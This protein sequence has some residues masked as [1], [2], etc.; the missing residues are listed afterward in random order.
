MLVFATIYIIPILYKYEPD[1]IYSNTISTPFGGM[2]SYILKVPNI[3]HVREF[4][5]EDHGYKFD[6]GIENTCRFIDE[7]SEKIIYNSSA[8]SNKYASLI[9]NTHE[10]TIHNGPIN[11]NK[12]NS[13][14]I[15]ENGIAEPIELVIVGRVSESK[16]QMEAIIALLLIRERVEASLRIVGDGD[17]DYISRCKDIAKNLGLENHIEWVGY[18]D[19]IDEEYRDADVTIVP[20]K[21]EAF[22]RVVI[23]S[24]ALG[25]PVVGR[26]S[27][28]I[29]E[30][31]E[32]GESGLLY[33][34]LPQLVNSIMRLY[35]EP[36]FY[37][38]ISSTAFQRALDNY[39]V[40]ECTT[41]IYEEISHTLNKN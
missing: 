41:M 4:V 36:E 2:L 15:K 29:P 20:S 34:E 38:S 22:G 6:I 1:L 27:G 32:S 37:T 16:N 25:T 10:C 33:S 7:T 21:C 40:D 39:T 28:G 11:T 19:E 14:N 17:E 13:Q 30:I 23:E 35:R 8:V 26:Q 31:I 5:E 9:D 12:F 3:W 24:M 18:K